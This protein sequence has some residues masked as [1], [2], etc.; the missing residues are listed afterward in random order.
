MSYMNFYGPVHQAIEFYT[1]EDFDYID[2]PWVVGIE[3]MMT[4][5]PKGHCDLM[6]PGTLVASGEQSFMELILTT[7]FHAGKYCCATPCYR[8]QDGL[9]NDG[10]HFAQ[11]FKVELIDYYNDEEPYE[12]SLQ[13]MISL[14][15]I[16]LEFARETRGLSGNLRVVETIDEPREQCTTVKSYDIVTQSGIELG[17]YGIRRHHKIGYWIYGTGAAFPRLFYRDEK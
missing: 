2:V 11:F 13:Q 16:Y 1:D 17:S 15:K 12:S 5:A 6:G 10:L 4:T 14:A 3:A 7:D 9:R 8:V